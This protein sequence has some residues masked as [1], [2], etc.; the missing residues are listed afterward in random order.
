MRSRTVG[1]V[2]LASALLAGGCS[3]HTHTDHVVGSDLVIGSGRIATES[4]PVAA[5]GAVTVDGPLLVQLQAG[6]ARALEV[7]AEDNLLAL[8]RSELRGDRLHLFLAPAS[9]STTQ[10]LVVRAC[11]A[12]LREI[13]ASGAARIEVE[14]VRGE[15]L[16][17]ALAGAA[18]AE[19]SGN[20]DR[21]E[22]RLSGAS[23][24]RAT[25]LRSRETIAAL[26]GASYASV[27]VSGELRV[28]ASGASTLEYLGD[29]QLV[30]TVSGQSV[31][32]RI[33]P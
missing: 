12:E 13:E 24:S 1:A 14:G 29:P 32:R 25:E 2:T 21:H 23:R 26:S 3:H 31:V 6:C 15:R 28:E 27:A 19:L 9:I 22:L 11:F 30:S 4:R 10:P 20:V 18:S 33:G 16:S 5:F 8:V 17:T 7:S